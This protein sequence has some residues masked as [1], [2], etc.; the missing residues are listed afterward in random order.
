[1]KNHLDKLSVLELVAYTLTAMARLLC[2]YYLKYITALNFVLNH[3]YGVKLRLTGSK[4]LLGLG[5]GLE[6][7]MLGLSLLART[8]W[9]PVC[10]MTLV[11]PVSITPDPRLLEISRKSALSSSRE[12]ENSLHFIA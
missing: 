5:L 8:E 9:V 2:N 1:M 3:H 10:S 11:L 4:S 7:T 6:T 12:S